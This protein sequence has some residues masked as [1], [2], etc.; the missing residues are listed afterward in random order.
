MQTAPELGD[1]VANV[2]IHKSSTVVR[3]M[4]EANHQAAIHRNILTVSRGYPKQ[5]HVFPGGIPG[6]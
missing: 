2:G 6:P 5:Q 1:F 3:H 4:G